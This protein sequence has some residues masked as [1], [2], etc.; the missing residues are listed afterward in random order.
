MARITDAPPTWRHPI[1]RAS[2]WWAKR[3]YGVDTGPA[4]IT[5]NHPRM[6]MGYGILETATEYSRTVDPKLKYLAVT[7]AAMVAGCEY[8]VDIG[9]ELSRKVGVPDEQLMEL[10]R[11]RDSDAFTDA[12]RDAIELGDRMTRTPVEVPDELFERLRSRLDEA[13]LVEL[14]SAIA[15]ENYRARFNH[16]FEIEPDG[17]SEGK[18]CVRPEAVGA[19]QVPYP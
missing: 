13:Q 4:R 18:F 9:S 8:C 5:A 6:F 10:V 15:V 14:V 7:R 17:F 11:Y 1:V 16:T 12:E 3:S 19:G 2:R